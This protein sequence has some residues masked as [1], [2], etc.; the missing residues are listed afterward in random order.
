MNANAAPDD[1]AVLPTRLD[2][3]ALARLQELDP[4]GRHGVVP[5]VLAAYET[6]LQRMLAQ[7]RAAQ[8]PALA[9]VVA[10]VAHTLKSSSASVGAL[11]LAKICAEI[12]ARLRS[13]NAT[14]LAGDLARLIAECE[15]AHG[16]VKAILRK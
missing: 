12:E 6:S 4:D 8:G 2:P 9:S 11:A 14:T 13:G 7:L 3:Q 10:N 15:V 5:R 1:G 16:A